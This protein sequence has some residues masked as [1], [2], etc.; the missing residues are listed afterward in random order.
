VASSKAAVAAE[1]SVSL[2]ANSEAHS[3]CYSSQSLLWFCY[4]SVMVTTN[5][6][7]K[8]VMASRGPPALSW[9]ST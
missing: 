9:A 5:S 4:S 6:S 7:S 1:I 8:A 2:K 3:T